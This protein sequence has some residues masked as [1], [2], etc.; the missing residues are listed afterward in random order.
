MDDIKFKLSDDFINKYKGKQ[1]KWGPLG[2]VTFKR[3]YARTLNGRTEEYWETL[4]RVVEGVFTIQKRHCNSN[5]LPWSQS[6]AKKS[7]ERMFEL[8]WEFKF[9]PPG[10]GL[11]MMGTDYVLNKGGASLN[12]CLSGETEF[13]TD[14]G[15]FKLK[16]LVGKKLK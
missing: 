10:R 16:D 13:Y 5:K 9:T 6:K 3:T 4:K 7:A 2:F 8:M 12:N 15:T 11:W 1:P 14:K